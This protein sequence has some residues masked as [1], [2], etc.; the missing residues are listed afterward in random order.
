MFGILD[1]IIGA[2]VEIAVQPV[3]DAIDV[4]A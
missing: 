3:V 1:D 2:A 4:A